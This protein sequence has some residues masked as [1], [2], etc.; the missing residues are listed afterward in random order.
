MRKTPC[1]TALHFNH[2]LLSCFPLSS[3]HTN[4]STCSSN[5]STK[6]LQIQLLVFTGKSHLNLHDTGKL[7]GQTYEICITYSITQWGNP[8]AKFFQ[9]VTLE[10]AMESQ[11]GLAEK[12]RD[13]SSHS[14]PCCGQEHLPSDQIAPGPVLNTSRDGA[15]AMD[16]SY[17]HCESHML[18]S[19]ETKLL[20]TSCH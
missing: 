13:S 16:M 15:R 14:N 20:G 1:F 8:A 9:D 4:I 12:G 11:N 7:L 6:I 17:P 5:F 19:S 2:H 3:L 10:G 18:I